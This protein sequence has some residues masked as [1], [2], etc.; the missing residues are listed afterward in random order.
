MTRRR[1]ESLVLPSRE[2][3]GPS[4]LGL[5]PRAVLAAVVAV[6]SLFALC[7]GCAG[8]RKHPWQPAVKPIAWPL[9]PDPPRIRYEGVVTTGQMLRFRSG[10]VSWV[11]DLLA[12]KP[13]VKLGTPHGISADATTL[14]VADSALG[15]VHVFHLR[16]RRYRT[17]RAA[18]DA[19]LLCPIGVAVDGSG[20]VFVTDSVMARVFHFCRR[21]RLV[22]EVAAD[23]V[24]PTGIA[25]DA[26]RGRL[27]VVDTGAHAVF[28]FQRDRERFSL[29]RRFGRHSKAPSGF[30]FP[31]HATVDGDG[32]LYVSDS[33]NFR[34]Q[35]FDP[36]GRL[37]GL[38]GHAG[39]GASDFAKAKGVAV[40]SEGHVYVVDSLFDVIQIFDRDGR[41]L[42][43]FGG[44]GQAEGCLWLP[45]GIAIDGE[46]R[47]Y[48]AD[49]GNSRVQVYRYVRQGP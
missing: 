2:W 36:D 39:H 29:L 34:I 40:D 21:G 45:T 38:F 27:H 11:L 15:L 46:D 44:Y 10:V 23:F 19:A 4:S 6:A 43:P 1:A 18:G 24:R 31:T 20:G 48:V 47:I 7:A 41:F 12:G 33:L 26:A 37:L 49:S 30:N 32:N 17:I 16:E 22:G 8:T 3:I 9:P 42:L 25:Y 28:S 14:A 13:E 5:R 35:V